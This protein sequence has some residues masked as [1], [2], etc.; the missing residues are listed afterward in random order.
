MANIPV[1]QNPVFT[2]DQ[3]ETLVFDLDGY[4]LVDFAKL[5]VGG[6]SLGF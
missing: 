2:T 6:L 4:M 1:E 5:T 3:P